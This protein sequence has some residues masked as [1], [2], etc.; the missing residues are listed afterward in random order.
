GRLPGR[1]AEGGVEGRPGARVTDLGD[2]RRDADAVRLPVPAHAA[3]ALVAPHSP[4]AAGELAGVAHASVAV[5]T[6]AYPSSAV[7]HPLDGSGFLVPR[8]EGWLLT[9]GTFVSS[10]W[11]ALTPPGQV[12]LRASAGRA[13]DD[14]ITRLSDDALATQLH[15]E[16]ARALDIAGEPAAVRVDRWPR[17]FPQYESGH[18]AR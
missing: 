18:Q 10:K 14:R 13:G 2:V 6:F 15:R 17:S 9:A 11:P 8:G 4:R 16:L 1:L 12:L 5:V 7:G 3:A